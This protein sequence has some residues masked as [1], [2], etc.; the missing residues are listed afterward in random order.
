M[1]VTEGNKKRSPCPLQLELWTGGSC[2]MWVLG[3]EY[4]CSAFWG[5]SRAPK[6]TSP[7]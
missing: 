1:Q 5:I 4:M 7:I 6:E 3:T 2:P